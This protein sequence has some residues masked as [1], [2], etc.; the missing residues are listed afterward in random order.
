MHDIHPS[1]SSI[2]ELLS[3]S[4]SPVTDKRIKL[5]LSYPGISTAVK[6]AQ[7]IDNL[8]SSMQD[9]PV[10]PS[11]LAELLN[12]SSKAFLS[13]MAMASS[14]AGPIVTSILA[15]SITKADTLIKQTYSP[16]PDLRSTEDWT[17][18]WQR[19]SY[20]L[21]SKHQKWP[22]RKYHNINKIFHS[23]KEYQ[24]WSALT[25]KYF[26]MKASSEC[27]EFLPKKTLHNSG[28]QDKDGIWKARHRLFE[29]TQAH[30][31]LNTSGEPFLI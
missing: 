31:A 5:W 22:T 17:K 2:K 14:Q 3:S 12:T 11:L 23:V 16:A 18:L 19:S 27:D 10:S 25:G 4:Y 24:E 6:R 26:M 7:E 28:I 29:A 21:T 15:P 30:P 1:Q 20:L 8:T 13:A 9:S